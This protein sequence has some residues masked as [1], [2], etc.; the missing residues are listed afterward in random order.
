MQQPKWNTGDYW[1]YRVIS[2]STIPPPHSKTIYSNSTTREEVIG[3]DNITIDNTS[4]RVIVTYFISYGIRESNGEITEGWSNV[5]SYYLLSNLSLIKMVHWEE[6]TTTL[7]KQPWNRWRYPI[8][9]GDKWIDNI[10]YLL[11]TPNG[12]HYEFNFTF[13]CECTRKVMVSVPAG[14]FSC[15]EIKDYPANGTNNS[16]NIFYLSPKVGNIVKSLSYNNGIVSNENVLLSF[17]YNGSSCESMN[18][19][20]TPGFESIFFVTCM[21]I[22]ILIR[23]WKLK[24]VY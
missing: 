14:N 1:E 5:T 3:Y 20:N 19:S 7:F 21:L 4:Y 10:D 11:Y 8:K 17:H 12:N 24:R 16:Y 22:I 15:Y 23:K 9:V 13:I 2:H 18:N 6:N